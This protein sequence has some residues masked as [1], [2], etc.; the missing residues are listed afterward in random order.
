MNEYS[1]NTYVSENAL[2]PGQVHTYFG[3]SEH[4]IFRA[5]RQEVSSLEHKSSAERVQILRGIL[6]SAGLK[7]ASQ[8]FAYNFNGG[9]VSGE[10][11][12]AIL[13]GPRAD[14]T[15]A[16]ALIA[17]WRTYDGEINYS[18]VA[19]VLTLARY[20]KRWSLWSKDI[21]FIIPEDSVAG[22]QAWADAYHDVHDPN[23]VQPLAVKA[24]ALQGAIAVE[25]PAG[26]WGHRFDKLHVR[27]DGVNGQLPN[28]DLL[29]TAV[30][31]ASGQMGMGCTIQRMWS[32]EDKYLDRLQTMLRG[33][34]NQGL[35]HA[36]GP[37]SAFMP[38]HVDAIT[39]QTVGD[40]WQDE[41]SLGRTIEG[42]F[43][44]LNN[45]L[46]HLHQS[47]FFYLLMNVNRFVSIGTYLPSAMLIAGAFTLMSIFEWIASG[48]ASLPY[49]PSK[50]KTVVAAV[51]PP[52][53]DTA[54]DTTLEKKE[55]IS[56]PKPG[57][58][59]SRPLFVPGITLGAISFLS[60]LPFSLFNYTSSTTI[61]TLFTALALPSPI[62]L[63]IGLPDILGI[64]DL[65]RR[66]ASIL[67]CFSF[68]LLGMFLST[69]ATINFSLSLIIGVLSTPLA[70]VSGLRPCEPDCALHSTHIQRVWGYMWLALLV[71]LS[72]MTVVYAASEM[73]VK[74]GVGEVLRQ[75][76]FGWWVCGQWTSVIVWLVWFPS[77][78][79]G[80]YV[81]SGALW[82][83]YGTGRSM[84]KA[85]SM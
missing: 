29:N 27:Y 56:A 5:Y 19:L 34:L 15:E 55:A 47:F 36:T 45:L 58:A 52:P 21:I 11:A 28:L 69:L 14:A 40:G 23:S 81:L 7:T 85:I 77:W 26:T 48:W 71:A 62:L 75:S 51:H 38:Y 65:S 54:K 83:S 18:G 64:E 80:V 12:Y 9:N 16:V 35:G 39:L 20:F 1:R 61:F 3:G 73:F 17:A 30:S 31:V 66:E 44:S 33:M 41:M 25:Y 8:Q 57:T 50:D 74:G 37:H 68:L 59:L 60:L 4:N 13:Q 63:A 6:N 32:H 22:P 43:R 53:Q 76:G 42:L 72:P 2:L 84:K 82:S 70:F 79:T 67:L 78:W 24:G 49:A 46:E 10:N